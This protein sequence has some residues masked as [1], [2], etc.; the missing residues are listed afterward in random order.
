MTV[1]AW[2]KS[3][4]V[5]DRFNTGTLRSHLTLGMGLYPR[6]CVFVILCN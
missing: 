4:I 1:A 2:S 3:R 6:F 5:F